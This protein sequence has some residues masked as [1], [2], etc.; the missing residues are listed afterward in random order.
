MKRSRPTCHLCSV[1]CL[2]LSLPVFADVIQLKGGQKIEGE[3]RQVGGAYEVKTEFATLTIPKEDAVNVVR[4][5]EALSADAEALHRKARALY[6]EALTLEKDQKTANA[7]LKEGVELLRKAADIYNEAAEAYDGKQHESLN[8]PTVI[9]KL[10]Q[11]MRLY[12]DKMSSEIAAAPAP[13][14]SPVPPAEP[15]PAVPAAEAPKPPEEAPPPTKIEPEPTAKVEAPTPPIVEKKDIVALR[16]RA[17]KGDPEAMYEAGL[18]YEF[19]TPGVRKLSESLKFYQR[20]ASRDNAKAMLRL[21]FFHRDGKGVKVNG[22]EARK[23]FEKAYEKGLGA[24]A[25]YAGITYEMGLGCRRNLV[26]AN[27]WFEKAADKVPVEAAG[28]DLIAVATLGHMQLLGRGLPEDIKKGASLIREAAMRGWVPA[29]GQMG[30]MYFE[31]FVKEGDAEEAMNWI[32]KSVEQGNLTSFQFLGKFYLKKGDGAKA[33][34]W[35][36]KGIQEGDPEAT[37][38]LGLMFLQGNGVGQNDQEGFRWVRQAALQGDSDAINTLG[39]YFE[40]SIGTRESEEEAVK[41]YRRAADL[42]NYLAQHNIGLYFIRRKNFREAVP[43]L[44]LAAE[45]G[46]LEAQIRL[47]ILFE[48]GPA[49]VRNPVEAERWYLTAAQNG[50]EAAKARLREIQKSKSLDKK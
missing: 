26:Q 44:R 9:S 1:A 35:F 6:D 48:T 5:I 27:R 43:W 31:D 38:R 50:E 24:G 23:L 22:V 32:L 40:T 36:K 37:F 49:G 10:F 2:F 45:A 11:E 28:G 17:E 33:M 8:L 39:V 18:Y 19:N 7:R 16:A 42:G 13:P 34:E 4:S 3:I 21:A 20:A 30:F 14:A 29:Q 25:Y 12:R 41:M 46:Y 47:A 15:P